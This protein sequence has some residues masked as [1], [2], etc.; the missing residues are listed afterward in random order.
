MRFLPLRKKKNPP[1]PAVDK[2]PE[3]DTPYFEQDDGAYGVTISTASESTGETLSVNAEDKNDPVPDIKVPFVFTNNYLPVSDRQL[4]QAWRVLKKNEK[5]NDTSELDIELTVKTTAKQGHFIDFSYKK[6]VYNRVRLFIFIDRSESMI[7]LQEFGRELC[8]SAQKSEIH[9]NTES[10]STLMWTQAGAKAAEVTPWFFY[11]T[12]ARKKG[13]FILEAEDE[14]EKRTLSDLFAGI[15]KKNIVVLIYSDAGSLVN[16]TEGKRLQKT[17]DFLD[18]LSR[19]TAYVSWLNPAPRYRWENT[20]A[21]DLE[22]E[23]SMFETTRTD[24]E[25]SIAALK[26]KKSAK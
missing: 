12:P 17:K 25:N 26:G 5:R 24:L 16:E 14:K 1:L 13:E 3:I 8:L 15:N 23:V 2:P 11:R 9:S 22:E 7:A 10:D 21:M 18:D 20:N 19:R 6:K 4:W